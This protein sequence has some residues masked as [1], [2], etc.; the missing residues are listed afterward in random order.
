MQKSGCD[1]SGLP[2]DSVYVA[3]DGIVIGSLQISDTVR[4]ES[5]KAIKELKDFGIKHTA[6]LSGDSAAS[7][8]AVAGECGLD[9]YA[10]SLLPE[11]KVERLN[12][13]K[14]DYGTTIFVGDGINDAPV[15]AAADAGAAMGLGSDAALESA[16]VVLVSDSPAQLPQALKICKRAMGVIRFNIVFALTVKAL[17]FLLVPF[18]LA[19]MWM[20]VAADVGV[21]VLSVL[22]ATRILRFGKR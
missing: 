10:A 5:A 9:E 3:A 20:A 7:C 17:V 8:A 19:N 22:N 4:P 2:A 12:K 21:S 16:D 6:M 11:Q 1:V 15:L 18:G 14:A 13:I